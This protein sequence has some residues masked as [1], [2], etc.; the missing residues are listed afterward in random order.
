MKLGQKMLGGASRF[1]S[2]P[3]RVFCPLL[4]D[5]GDKVWLCSGTCAGLPVCSTSVPDRPGASAE[6]ILPT[7]PMGG[8]DASGP[9]GEPCYQNG[10]D[11]PH[12][13]PY[14]L[15]P[16]LVPGTLSYYHP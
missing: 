7:V 9:P 1:Q 8:P 2:N 3:L 11:R 13:S 6:N 5:A 16:V 14:S 10:L 4:R 12:L 15:P